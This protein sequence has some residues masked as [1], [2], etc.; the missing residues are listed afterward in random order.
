MEEVTVEEVAVGLTGCMLFSGGFP[1]GFELQTRARP[2]REGVGLE[3]ADVTDGLVQIDFPNAVEREVEPLTVALFPVQRR[4]PPLR[5]NEV[6]ALGE[7]EA[8]LGV[9]T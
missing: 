4:S 3:I 1:L 6:P 5:V 8:R 2:V 7:P 9:S